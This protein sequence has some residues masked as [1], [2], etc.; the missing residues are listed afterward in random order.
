M[1][2]KQ[3]AQPILLS[4]ALLG[5]W[6]ARALE[7]T[8]IM[9]EGKPAVEGVLV[10]G[11]DKKQPIVVLLGGFETGKNAVDLVRDT[12]EFAFAS[13]DYP[14]KLEGKWTK[15]VILQRGKELRRALQATREALCPFLDRLRA[16]PRVDAEK[17]ILLGASF[18]VP[19]ALYAA[20][21]CAPVR[22]LILVHGFGDLP[23]TLAY[24]LKTSRRFARDFGETWRSIFANTLGQVAWRLLDLPKPEKVARQL[25]RELPVLW[26]EASDDEMI[27][28][29]SKAALREALAE[30]RTLLDTQVM[31]GRHLHPGDTAMIKD[32]IARSRKWLVERKIL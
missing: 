30:D 23:G 2:L 27:P 7:R 18:G 20:K 26:L 31:K 16:D 13:L 9:I 12:P 10:A 32:I 1:F 4:L 14:F 8:A 19:Y 17:M 29:S 25:P 5:A 28:E 21:D 11:P 6:S 15:D 24:R 3:F 22:A